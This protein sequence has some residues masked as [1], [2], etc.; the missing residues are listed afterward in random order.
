[1]KLEEII[2]NDE[3]LEIGRRAIEDELVTYRDARM[4][5]PLRGNGLVISER[6]GARSDVVRF[7]S[8]TALRIGLDAIARHLAEKP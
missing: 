4:C 6:N 8:E 5:E 7:G 3:L 2:D 1:M